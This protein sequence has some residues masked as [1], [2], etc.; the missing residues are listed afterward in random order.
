MFI[1]KKKNGALVIFKGVDAVFIEYE[2]EVSFKVRGTPQ[3]FYTINLKSESGE[4]LEN[5]LIRGFSTN[6]IFEEV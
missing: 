5:A 1:I 2:N 6:E 4:S 3:D